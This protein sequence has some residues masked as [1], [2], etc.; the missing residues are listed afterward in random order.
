MNVVQ[1]VLRIGILSLAGLLSASLLMAKASPLPAGVK[2]VADLPYGDAGEANWLD[3]YSPENATGPLPL[4]IWIHGGGWANGD[5]SPS[6][7]FLQ[8]VPRGFAVASINYRLSGQSPFPAQIEDCKAAVRWLRAHAKDYNLDPDRFGVWGLSAGG[9][10]AALLGTSGDV[11]ELEGNVG[12]HLEVSSRVQAVSDYAGPTDLSQFW[13]QAGEDNVFWKTKGDTYFDRLFGK[14]S[15]EDHPELIA[16]A[17]PINFISTD[18]PP[19]QIFH[20]VKDVLV[21][22][23]QAEIFVAAL[24]AKGVDCEYTPLPTL[25]H[26]FGQLQYRE[27]FAF[28]EKHLQKGAAPVA[29][30]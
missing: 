18:D 5:K 26:G 27:T 10:L 13:A 8:L 3:I 23:G 2:V 1:K 24:K 4:V 30:R 25:G 12:G 15:L 16:R 14:G 7:Q 19:F 17:N 6:P 11:K 29:P 21:P 9:H 22:I 28:F 20:G